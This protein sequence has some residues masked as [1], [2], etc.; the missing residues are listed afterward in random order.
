MAGCVKTG[1]YFIIAQIVKGNNRE[2]V[3]LSGGMSTKLNID[4]KY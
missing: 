3:E 1:D 2:S 4:L